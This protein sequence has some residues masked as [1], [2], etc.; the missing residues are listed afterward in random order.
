MNG[1]VLERR[2][3]GY[4]ALSP[5]EE[6]RHAR[7]LSPAVAWPTLA[8]AVLL[9]A[10]HWATV[11]LGLA[12]LLPLWL[13]API[14]TFTAYAHYTLVHESHPRQPRARPSQAALA[15]RRGRLGRRARPFLQLADHDAR[16]RPA[17]R[18]HQHRSG[19]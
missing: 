3:D 1:A 2:M 18:P 17:P 12:R 9:P 11:G 7:E 16:P 4:A 15:E 5:P 14:L 6:K 10:F 13:C 8:M 19:P